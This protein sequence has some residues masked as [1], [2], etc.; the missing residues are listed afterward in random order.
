M[1]RRVNGCKF[2]AWLLLGALLV[3]AGQ[4]MGNPADYPNRR[5]NNY[6]V[7]LSPLILWWEDPRGVRPLKAWKHLQGTFEGEIGPAWKIRCRV[8]G[9]IAKPI[10]LK[11]PPQD[12]LV[13]FRELQTLML[14]L[15]Q[16]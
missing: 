1:N 15:E 5:I 11:N 13:R 12:R 8:E 16:A 3:R 2:L 9:E 4:A 6:T 10:L 14:K 7:D